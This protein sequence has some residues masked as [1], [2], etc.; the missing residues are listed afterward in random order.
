LHGLG[1]CDRAARFRPPPAV[2]L[3]QLI[4]LVKELA[5][6]DVVLGSLRSVA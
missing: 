3:V 4:E 2:N 1:V 6:I 5:N